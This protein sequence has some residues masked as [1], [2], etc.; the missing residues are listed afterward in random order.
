MDDCPNYLTRNDYKILKA[1]QFKQEDNFK[2]TNGLDVEPYVDALIR[3][4]ADNGYS[5][6]A[7]AKT[8]NSKAI[9]RSNGQP[10]Q[11]FQISR[12]MTKNGVKSACEWRGSYERSSS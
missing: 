7:I 10:W 5:Q 11:Q 9:Y 8:L 2:R 3:S 6:A 4:L 12:W 1:H